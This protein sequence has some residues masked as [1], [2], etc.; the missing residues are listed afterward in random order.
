[1]YYK[2]TV[3]RVCEVTD[4]KSEVKFD[5]WGHLE[6]AMASE[7]M[8]IAFRGNIHIDIRVIEVT[9]LNFEVKSDLWGQN[10][11][12]ATLEALLLFLIVP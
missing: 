9:E 2:T 4:L 11:A 10:N 7:V 12:A 1:M 3:I 8:K 6:A 5:L